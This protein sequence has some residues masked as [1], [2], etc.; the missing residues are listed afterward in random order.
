MNLEKVYIVDID[1][2][3]AKHE[4]HRGPFEE[5]LVHLDTALP[6]CKVIH[7]LITGGNRVIYFSGRTDKCYSSTI[8]WILDN[9]EGYY[10]GKDVD[11][12]NPEP[13]LYM[14][15]SGDSRGDDIIKKELYDLHIKDKY[16]VIGVFDDRL[17]VVRM[18]W[19]L[20]LF[21]F[22][23]NQGNIEF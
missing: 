5:H 11:H 13:E 15:K 22:N 19:D 3:L 14:R 4:P 6:T 1:G 2:T 21:V 12:M 17:K 16:E 10:G 8:K 18:W 20:G 7:E 23:C 9:I